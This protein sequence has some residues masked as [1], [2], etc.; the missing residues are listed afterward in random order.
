VPLDL[1]RSC[2]ARR[3]RSL[4][5]PLG[6]GED[7][8]GDWTR[9]GSPCNACYRTRRNGCYEIVEW[10]LLT[11]RLPA[12]PSRHRVAVWRE[13]R[14]TGALSLQQATWAVPARG[15][16]L[17][18]VSR[19]V[20]LVER[21]GGEALVFDAAP[22]G[23]EAEEQLERLFTAEREEEWKEFLAECGKFDREI[24][25]EIESEKFTA[26]ELD[27]EEQN[28]D[29]LRR[30]F[31]ELRGRDLFVAPSQEAA[32]RRLADC[33]ERLDGFAERVYEHGGEI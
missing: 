31:R 21:A 6:G 2:S 18:S 9:L 27:E 14:R 13:L 19:A 5:G 8:C 33:A 26:A 16:F 1:P 30:W 15:E 7:R 10:I 20:A 23:D 25:R 3:T 4:Y 28:L 29:R 12:E 22:K 32:K 24:D 17:S 11:Y